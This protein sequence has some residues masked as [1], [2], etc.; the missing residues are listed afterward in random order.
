M[1]RVAATDDSERF[2]SKWKRIHTAPMPCHI[3]Q[4]L[5]LRELARLLQHGLGRVEPFRAAHPPSECRHYAAWSASHVQRQ[6]FGSCAGRLH[7]QVERGLVVMHRRRCELGG[8]PSELV[9]N[10]GI[11]CGGHTV[12]HS[13]WTDLSNLTR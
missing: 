7:Q 9:G 2:V 8:L 11:V 1:E 4:A 12:G 5:P 3:A 6:I 10:G 13:H